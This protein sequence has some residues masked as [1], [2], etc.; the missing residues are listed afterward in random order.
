MSD[1]PIHE[2][3]LPSKVDPFKDAAKSIYTKLAKASWQR[4]Q[5][6]KHAEHLL[7]NPNYDALSRQ[8]LHIRD[9]S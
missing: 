5:Q 8:T 4:I 1:M 9:L 7:D 6:K 3:T 2:Q